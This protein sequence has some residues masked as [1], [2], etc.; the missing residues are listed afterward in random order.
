MLSA[1]VL[2]KRDEENMATISQQ[3]RR[4]TRLQDTHNTLN[5]KLTKQCKAQ[6]S[7]LQALME[8]YRK[9]TEQYRDVQKKA[10]HFQTS[11]AK[12]FQDIWT[13]NE[14]RVRELAQD[15]MD[16]DRVVHNQ[17]LGLSWT[18]PQ[19]VPSPMTRALASAK[20]KLSQA[21]MYASQILSQTGSVTGD[22][23]MAAA[24]RRE[25]DG[26]REGEGG[27]AKPRASSTVSPSMQVHPPAL[28]KRVLELLC[29]EAEFLLDDKLARL[30]APL[31][32][33]EQIMMKLD[34]MFKSLG[35]HTE[36]D[37]QR[38]V[39]HFISEEEG[40][41]GEDEEDEEEEEEGKGDGG[42]PT[43]DDADSGL[44]EEVSRPGTVVKGHGTSKV[45]LIHPNNIPLA[46]RRFIE[47]RKASSKQPSLSPSALGLSSAA[48]K[49]LLD[50]S[51]WQQITE[52]LPQSHE[53]VWDALLDGLERYHSVLMSRSKCTE[54]TQALA[55]QNNELRLLLQQYMRSQINRELEIPPTL[56]LPVASGVHS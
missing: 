24:A 33:A 17:Q 53:R 3:K 19:D 11:D 54:E 1:Q 26:E 6:R 8:E 35:I 55:V 23:Y 25:G 51:F 39:K 32:K 50:G 41:E 16:A 31:E 12:R 52:V 37:I 46:I 48:Q 14:E 18:E 43:T 10:K 7:E 45:T 47:H 42:R 22:G 40:K 27:E 38:L 28:V 56:M 29:E 5:T 9:N 36:D 34:S 21:T 13:M 49:E 44:A 2:K 30:L 20:T 15:V 4:I